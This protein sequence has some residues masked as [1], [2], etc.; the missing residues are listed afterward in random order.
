MRVASF[1]MDGVPT[2]P[3]FGSAWANTPV[4]Q[5]GDLAVSGHRIVDGRGCAVSLAGVSLFWSNSGWGGDAFYNAGAIR[6]VRDDWGAQVIRAAMGVEGDGGYLAD[7]GN[8]AKVEGVVRAAVQAGVYVIIDWHS[9]HAEDHQAEAVAFFARMAKKF[10]HLPNVIY[11]VYNEPL[12]GVSWS[13][14]VKPYAERVIDAI[15][16]MDPDNLIIV[17]SPTWS[18]DVDVAAADPIVGRANVAYSLHF[19]AETHRESL[20]AKALAAL[21]NGAPL[22]VTE[23]GTV[24][25]W[26]RGSVAESSVAEWMEFLA[27]HKISHCNWSLNDRNEAAS[28]LRAGADPRGGWTSAAL[29]AS[30]K[31]VKR[32]IEGWP[33]TCP[34]GLAPVSTA[35]V[36][37]SRRLS[38]VAP[39]GGI[40]GAS[41]PADWYTAPGALGRPA[42]ADSAPTWAVAHPSQLSTVLSSDGRR[43]FPV[44]G[45]P[46]GVAHGPSPAG[47]SFAWDLAGAQPMD[48]DLRIE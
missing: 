43:M 17:G 5:H 41:A 24:N 16:E 26:A 29:T 45:Y 47:R 13:S 34:P 28:A 15:R 19:Y 39:R 14:T 3:R 18:Q 9:H 4:Q 36:S 35:A 6:W 8:E 30:G 10:G 40:F 27:E 11:E 25:A 44:E 42:S 38:A 22:F 21:Q 1:G 23:W 33:V 7:R 31:L 48:L 2:A 32:I 12:G 20:R 37:W 46:G